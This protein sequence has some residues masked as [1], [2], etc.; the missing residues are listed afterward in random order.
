MIIETTDFDVGKI[1][2]SGQC[3]RMALNENGSYDVIYQRKYLN[4]K[5]VSYDK[6]TGFF[7][8]ELDCSEEDYENVWK[9]YF[10]METDYGKMAE[11]VDREDIF[12]NEAVRYG[13]GIRI[14]RQDPWEMLISFII[15]QRKSIPAIR[16]SVE[17]LCKLCGEAID[18]EYGVKYAFPDA[19]AVAG[20]TMEELAGCG[21][22]YRAAY[23]AETA[24][25]A[26]CGEFDVYGADA[27]DDGKLRSELMSLHG[28]GVKVADCVMLFG[29][30]RL[31]SFPEDVW[32]KRAMESEYPAGFPYDKYDGYGGIMQQYIFF[33]IRNRKK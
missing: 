30:R 31:N 29:Y 32:I 12:L 14:L 24:R 8:L 21:I 18:T 5:P 13:K 17:R 33:Y 16:T 19:Q 28:V 1:A 20:L 6:T 3:F 15:S 4:I 10:D 2:E 9:S 11:L 25:R 26:A 27:L 22:G 23:V 7:S